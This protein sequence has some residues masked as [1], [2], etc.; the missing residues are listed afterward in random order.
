MVEPLLIQLLFI[1]TP[2]ELTHNKFPNGW[3]TGA[4]WVAFL[5]PGTVS[6]LNNP[7]NNEM[8]FG[9]DI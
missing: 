9:E 4:C 3:R 1:H 5:T 2:T 7:Q 6:S 8:N